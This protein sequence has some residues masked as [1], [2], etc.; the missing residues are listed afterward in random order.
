M[1][2]FCFLTLGKKLFNHI[3]SWHVNAHLNKCQW[4]GQRA[5]VSCL[6]R[7]LTSIYKEF[8][9]FFHVNNLKKS[10]AAENKLKQSQVF[11][12]KK[13]NNELHYDEEIC[14]RQLT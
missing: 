13:E 9:T 5:W 3:H 8:W 12:K 10:V 14:L 2:Y 11:G 4:R 1:E 7:D 6:L